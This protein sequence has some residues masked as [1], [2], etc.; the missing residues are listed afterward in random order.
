[1]H[2]LLLLSITLSLGFACYSANADPQDVNSCLLEKLKKG[3]ET[4]TIGQVRQLCSPQAEDKSDESSIE[5]DSVHQSGLVSQRLAREASTELDQFVITPHKQ[6]YLLPVYTTNAINRQAYSEINGFE[7][8]LEDIESMF[9]LSIK[10]P[11]TPRGLFIENDGFFMGFTLQAFWQV[12]SQGISKPFRETNYQPEIFYVAPI[13]YE[14]FGTDTTVVLGLEHQSNGR[15]QLL[16]RSWNR[17][18]ANFLFEKNNWV[19]SVKPWIRLPEDDKEF[20]LDPNGDDNPDIGDFMGHFELS[21]A[22]EWGVFEF[23]LKGRQ[24]FNTHNGSAE[25]GMTFPLWG[26]FRGYSKVFHGYGDSLIDYDYSQTR[27][28][29]GFALNNIF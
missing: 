22:Y 28:G 26:K 13:H 24:N 25:L 8:N 5:H 14:V 15:S 16:S 7:D 21:A 4:L 20:E 11:L 1:M 23:S 29:V 12:Y 27:V 19:I 18:Y 10:A 9:Q 3:D 2:R 6:N 17:V